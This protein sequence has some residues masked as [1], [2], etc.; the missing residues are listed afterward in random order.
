MIT[1]QRANCPGP[2]QDGPRYLVDRLWPRGVKKAEL[3]LDGWLKDVSPSNALRRRYHH[4]PT[5]WEEFRRRYFRELDANPA[6]WELLLQAARHGDVTLV[7][8]A[9]DAERNN[10]VALKEYLEEKLRHETSTVAA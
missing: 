1:M 3:H 9:H 2:S 4:D 8:G 10:A 6:A 5:K 7:Y